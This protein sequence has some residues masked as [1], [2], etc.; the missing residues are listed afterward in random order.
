MRVMENYDYKYK[1][2]KE[3]GI[4]FDDKDELIKHINLVWENIND[5]WLNNKTQEKIKLFN[6]KFNISYKNFDEVLNIFEK[7]D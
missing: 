4:Y 7:I 6:S 3:A 5:W 1:I 2:L